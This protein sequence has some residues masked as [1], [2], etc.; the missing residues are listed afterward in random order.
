MGLARNEKSPA[1]SRPS[2]PEQSNTRL[3]ATTAGSAVEEQPLSPTIDQSAPI[4]SDQ[5]PVGDKST[6]AEDPSRLQGA[7]GNGLL[8]AAYAEPPP[9]AI[10]LPDQKASPPKEAEPAAKE[11]T[12]SAAAAKAGPA[13]KTARGGE[14]S[15]ERFGESSPMQQTLPA[16]SL[17]TAQPIPIPIVESSPLEAMADQTAESTSDA[18]SQI[19]A[20]AAA[21]V[22]QAWLIRQRLLDDGNASELRVHELFGRQRTTARDATSAAISSVRGAYGAAKAGLRGLFAG[23]RAAIQAGVAEARG[24]V[25]TIEIGETATLVAAGPTTVGAL[26][27]S[28]ARYDPEAA[29]IGDNEARRVTSDAEAKAGAANALGQS[30]AEAATGNAEIR[31]EKADGFRAMGSKAAAH[32]RDLGAQSAEK[33]RVSAADAQGLFRGQAEGLAASVESLVSAAVAKLPQLS[34]AVLD[35]QTT[36]Q[37]EVLAN[38]DKT[39]TATLDDIALAEQTA[40]GGLAEGLAKYQSLLDEAEQKA[41]DAVRSIVGVEAVELETHAAA[42]V[43]M[44][45]GGTVKD[46]A[47]AATIVSLAIAQQSER[48]VGVSAALGRSQ[49]ALEQETDGAGGSFVDGVA[50]GE[51]ATAGQITQTLDAARGNL[52]LMQAGVLAELKKEVDAYAENVTT[53]V[54]TTVKGLTELVTTMDGEVDHALLDLRK[55]IAAPVDQTIAENEKGLSQLPGA[56]AKANAEI[57]ASHDRGFWTKVWDAIVD[58]VTSVLFWVAI[59]VV[60]IAALIW[61]SLGALIAGVIL[62]AIGVVYTTYL[63]IK[64]LI[65]DDAPWYRWVTYIVS[66]PFIAVIDGLGLF[67]LIEGATGYDIVTGRKLSEDEAAQRLA[68]GSGIGSTGVTGTRGA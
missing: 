40:V 23:A 60:V 8:A 15:R 38:C 29:A 31:Q 63:R 12:P 32:I 52:A 24:Q 45:D 13:P 9:A 28:T 49:S 39:A 43:A 64:S 17:P 36:L 68:G 67:G 22:E 26:K 6:P 54:T 10:D 19:A 56:L 61:G 48:Q 37:T 20:L 53:G 4:S 55:V 35:R 21:F 46:P 14:S 34:K 44:L 66:W 5:T 7:F 11:G 3:G 57:D 65:D 41:A 42:I 51:A 30:R 47:V 27:T 59:A 16:V 18:R 33:A 25:L 2:G 62:L 1:T 58:I 50:A